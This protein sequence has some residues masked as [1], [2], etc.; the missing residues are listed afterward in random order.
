LNLDRHQAET[1]E[2]AV[3]GFVVQRAT[4]WDRVT[5]GTSFVPAVQRLFAER[6][7]TERLTSADRFESI[8][9]G[10]ALIG[11]APDPDRWTVQSAVSEHAPS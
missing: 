11:H 10:L 8:A 2:S 4:W 9:Y 6:F 5:G 3:A 1:T 7:G